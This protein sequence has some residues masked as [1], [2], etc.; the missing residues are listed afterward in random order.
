MDHIIIVK[1]FLIVLFTSLSISFFAYTSIDA[2]TTGKIAGEVVDAKTG[3]PLRGVN[4]VISGT[5]IGAAT[6]ING[7]YFILNIPPATYRLVAT[8][9][10]YEEYIVKDVRVSV[11]RTTTIN[12][13]LSQTV[14]YL[15]ESVVVVAERE[16]IQK[17]VA[18][19]QTIMASSTLAMLP[20][21]QKLESTLENLAGFSTNSQGLV[22]RG[23][24]EREIL[25][26]N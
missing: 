2:G 18:Y 17:D 11:D 5:Q 12:I 23:S 6:D 21:D 7:K 1:K 8:M 13:R 9:M 3:E 14:L 4:V 24:D 15:G 16:A 10:G 26:N 25:T 20:T 22:I 19:S